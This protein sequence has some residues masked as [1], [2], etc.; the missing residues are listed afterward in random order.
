MTMRALLLFSGLALTTAS[1]LAAPHDLHDLQREVAVQ[2][3]VLNGQMQ[4][5]RSDV[6]REQAVASERL[7][8]TERTVDLLA[9][10]ID[11]LGLM[12][13][14]FSILITLLA[15][16][17]GF[18]TY[19]TGTRQA[20]ETAR[21]WLDEQHES[22][23][24]GIHAEVAEKQKHLSDAIDRAHADIDQRRQ[25]VEGLAKAAESTLDKALSKAQRALDAQLQEKDGPGGSA[26]LNPA[27][28]RAL[29]D[30][31]RSIGEKPE[32]SYSADDWHTRGLAAYAADDFEG[33]AYY[34]KRAIESATD[35]AQR[36]RSQTSRASLLTRLGQRQ[37]ALELLDDVVARFGGAVPEA[38][39]PT[40]AKALYGRA[41]VL[42]D[43]GK[44]K[45]AL[46]VVDDLGRRFG[47]HPGVEI[48]RQMCVAETLRGVILTEQDKAEEAVAAYTEVVK[49]WSTF[50][51][52]DIV[53]SVALAQINLAVI[54]HN[55]HRWADA[56][57]IYSAVWDRCSPRTERD[58][59]RRAA[60]AAAYWIES[61]QAL[62]D[63]AGVER[64]RG[65]LTTRLGNSGDSEVI[66]LIREAS[67]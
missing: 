30:E 28:E 25:H 1:A 18:L 3:E 15:V 13:A 41:T 57:A 23:V 43:L 36:A 52:A 9:Q 21:R 65:L 66:R 49:R 33:S 12:I 60:Q 16:L 53:D 17:A 5:L 56:A 48:Q 20:R 67:V 63:L 29:E 44:Y 32:A 54:H 40:V 34:F 11:D 31:S 61:L 35:D 19:F 50:E 26:S 46:G 39:A 59:E 55:D 42:V 58:L 8:K 2:K 38:V 47:A 64:V 7:A 45:E 27:E 62:G 51:D 4:G 14:F 10:R 22:I 6:S 24:E 37:A